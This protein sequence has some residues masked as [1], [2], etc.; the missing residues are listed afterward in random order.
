MI[1]AGA[2]PDWMHDGAAQFIAEL[3]L[4]FATVTSFARDPA[5]FA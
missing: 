1:P 2:P 4:F 5:A 3:R